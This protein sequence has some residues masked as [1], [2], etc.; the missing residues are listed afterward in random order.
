[1]PTPPYRDEILLEAAAAYKIH[2]TYQKTADALGWEWTT[3]KRRVVRAAQK[4]MLGTGPVL[5][6]FSIARVTNTPK[7]DFIQQRPEAGPEFEVRDGHA[8]K[9]VSAL[10]DAEGR[11]INQWIKTREEV[12]AVDTAE[13]L[14]KAFDGYSSPVQPTLPPAGTSEKLHTFIPCGDWHL[15]LHVWHR[16]AE[17]NWDLKTAVAAIGDGI[18]DVISRSPPSDR[19]L[20]VGGGDMTHADNNSNE[21]AKSRNKLDVDGRHQK[22]TEAAGQ[23]MVRTIETCLRR[24]RTA[25]VRILKGN[26]D[27]ETATAIAWFL[28]AWYRN[29]PRVEVDLDQSLFWHHQHGQVMLSAT[30]THTVKLKDMPQIMAH[31]RAEMW[32]ATKYRYAHGFHIHHHSKMATE[33]GGVIMESHQAPIPQ[34][35]W[36][37]G[38]G[39]LSGRS[40]QAITY[41]EERGEVSRVR[42]AMLDAA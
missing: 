39:Y 27:E 2:K 24:H 16:Q 1:M 40:L 19:A 35:A 21:T 42:R 3:T 10:V 22:V 23:L 34:D 31:R 8:I 17:E 37:Y 25:L 29:E 15:G 11:V 32:G 20:I 26:H 4:G 5:P 13:I 36:H 41:H 28:S 18:E 33:G 14:K 38:S 30:H 9:G 7:G 12:S 6:G